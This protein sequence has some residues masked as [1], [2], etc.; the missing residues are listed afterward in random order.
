MKNWCKLAASVVKAEFADFE[1]KAAMS[2][3]KL[4]R[5]RALRDVAEVK[6]TSSKN[7]KRLAQFLHVDTEKLISQFWDIKPTAAKLFEQEGITTEEAWSSTRSMIAFCASGSSFPAFRAVCIYVSVVFAFHAC[8]C[9]LRSRSLALCVCALLAF[10]IPPA[11]AFQIRSAL[12][13][14]SAFRWRLSPD[15]VL[16]SPPPCN[17]PAP[18]SRSASAFWLRLPFGLRLRFGGILAC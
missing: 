4:S 2:I 13:L 15:C 5:A 10:C 9:S 11:P 14:R 8:A 3:F 6:T 17:D 1:I 12:Q 18:H 7:L 16:K